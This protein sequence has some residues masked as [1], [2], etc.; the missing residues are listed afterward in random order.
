[1][2]NDTDLADPQ[3]SENE[4]NTPGEVATCLMIRSGGTPDRLTL[5]LWDT[6]TAT[7]YS[8]EQDWPVLGENTLLRALAWCGHADRRAGVL[9]RGLARAC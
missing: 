2:V 6:H 1:M 5:R 7:L 9:V 3:A 8:T 4:A